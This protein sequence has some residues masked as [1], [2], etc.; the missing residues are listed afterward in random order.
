MLRRFAALK[1]GVE[2]LRLGVGFPFLLLALVLAEAHVPARTFFVG[3]LDFA[4]RSLDADRRVTATRP[5]S[6]PQPRFPSERASIEP[7]G[8]RGQAQ[9]A[10]A[11]FTAVALDA[12]YVPFPSVTGRPADRRPDE[13]APAA[14]RPLPYRSHAPPA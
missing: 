14:A 8:W 2:G 12:T 4:G 9:S 10:P 3:L 5:E 1:S 11:G 6:Q 7:M 13:A